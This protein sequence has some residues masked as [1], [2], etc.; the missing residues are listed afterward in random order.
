MIALFVR[1]A[2]AYALLT[3]GLTGLTLTVGYL[4]PGE[5]QLAFVS[6]RSG[7]PGLYLLDVTHGLTRRLLHDDFIAFAPTWSPDGRELAF[8]SNRQGSLDVYILN[9][10][11]RHIRR[12][13]HNPYTSR[14]DGAAWSP[15]GAHIA[16][17][18][19][20]GG[21]YSI[22]I[23]DARCDAAESCGSRQAISNSI[24]WD[25]M[26]A[27]S[28]DSQ[29]LAFASTRERD[30]VNV[31]VLDITSGA[32]HRLTDDL[33]EDFSPAWSPDGQ[34]LVYTTRADGTLRMYLVSAACIET[35]AACQPRRLD[36]PGDVDQMPAWSPDGR[37]LAFSSMYQ[38]NFELFVIDTDGRGVRRLTFNRADDW[39]PAWRP[40]SR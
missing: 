28:P 22:Y 7:R 20:Q 10:L 23:L 33:V 1:F 31:F 6:A 39:S 35:R 18:T 19:G 2:L 12:L 16:F 29:R 11:T 32:I 8:I 17:S 3:A 15:D 27:W 38:G 36:G 40:I 5:G 21:I 37:R 30:N 13:T 14:S 24:H 4:L 34:Q 9:L 26:P 25:A